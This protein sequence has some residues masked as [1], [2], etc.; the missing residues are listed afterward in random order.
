MAATTYLPSQPT[1]SRR[2]FLLAAAAAAAGTVLL[3]GDLVMPDGLQILA[4][5]RG[6]RIPVG[7]I[8]GSAGLTSLAAALAGTASRVV[9]AVGSRA[10]QSLAGQAARVSLLGLAS[11]RHTNFDAGTDAVLLDAHFPSPIARDQTIAFFAYT[12][13]LQP[14]WSQS[15]PSRVHLVEGRGLRV[16]FR[17]TTT[18]AAPTMA[19]T[20]LSSRPHASLP[21]MQPGV[22]LFGLREGMWATPITVPAVDDSSWAGLPSI[23]VVVE[24]GSPR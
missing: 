11:P 21:T 3:G 16:G 23:V 22:Y 10:A 19:S 12:H 13:R 8:E 18:G 1:T 5:T 24:A 17:I 6:L 15:T 14:L 9:P 4:D 20:V 7:F 2:Q